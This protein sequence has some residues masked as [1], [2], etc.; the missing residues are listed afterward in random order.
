MAVLL[1]AAPPV[2]HA[3]PLAAVAEKVA[4]FHADLDD[5]P[6]PDPVDLDYDEHR[7]LCDLNL[8]SSFNDTPVL[9]LVVAIEAA[10]RLAVAQRR[11]DPID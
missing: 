1:A 10:R 11:G 4:R 7:T 6:E 8:R 9:I 5:D 2:P 3:L